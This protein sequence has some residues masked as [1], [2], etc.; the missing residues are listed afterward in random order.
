MLTYKIGDVIGP[1]YSEKVTKANFRC[2]GK[3]K[4]I[5]KY[6]ADQ[7]VKDHHHDTGEWLRAYKCPDCA[8]F[9]IGHRKGG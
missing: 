2:V 6:Y 5:S 4:F 9:H 7:A 3:R 8:H 1:K